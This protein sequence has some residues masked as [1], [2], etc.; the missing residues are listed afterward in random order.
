[1]KAMILE[2]ICDM[3]V[4]K[5]PLKSVEIPMPVP[6]ENEI[7]IKI[8]A[9][10]VCH[11]EL[12]EIEG[13][14]SPSFFPVIPGH[15]VA[16]RVEAKGKKAEKF[17]AGD[18][19]A[20]GWIFSCCGKCRFCLNGTENLCPDFKATGRDADGGYAE[21]MAIN[22]N[23]AYHVPKIFSYAEAAPLL[24]AGAVGWR[25]MKLAGIDDGQNIGLAGFGA[26]GHLVIK[27]IRKKYPGS[28]V[29][30]F[31]R[32]EE[33]RN[34]AK[35]LG[36]FWTGNFEQE[37]PQEL[38]CIIDT[39][40]VWA[41]VVSTL[42]NLESGGRFV[43]NAIRKESSDINELAKISYQQDLWMEKEIKSVANITPKDIEEFLELAAEIPIKPEIEEFTLEEANNALLEIKFRKIRG[44]KVLKIG[45]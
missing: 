13:R 10:G 26:S 14:C 27:V 45:H 11:T 31:S 33:E 23:F 5:A 38:N 43:I 41:P 16:G 6:A 32:T 35:Q 20:A 7:L 1:M 34:F 44:A 12:D 40:P 3:A 19:V 42:K 22:E 8:A 24:C 9:C 4:D 17:S 18:S 2:R 36:A 21:Y 30:V 37:T 25:S 29:F 15:Q 39:T 28:K